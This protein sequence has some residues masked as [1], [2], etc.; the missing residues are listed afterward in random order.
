MS[1]K[2]VDWVRR[3]RRLE[4][5]STFGLILVAVAMVG[6]FASRFDIGTL[7]IYKWIYAAGALLYAGARL[8]G[9][10]NRCESLRLRRLRR[11]EFWAGMAF[12]AGAF[13]WFYNDNR[14]S[15]LPYVGPLAIL[16][17]TVLFSLAGALIQ[18][19][20]SWMISVRE[21]KEAGGA[22]VDAGKNGK[23]K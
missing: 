8:V 7:D 4:A 20:A 12:C 19:I 17:N 18:V 10:C 9:A 5:I 14:L 16:R 21:K 1:E 15:S 3:R 2:R 23:G 6:P 22:A 11:M 13:F